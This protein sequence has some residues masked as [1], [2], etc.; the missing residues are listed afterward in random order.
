MFRFFEEFDGL[1]ESINLESHH[2]GY[3]IYSIGR[4]RSWWSL[5]NVVVV[6][7]ALKSFFFFL[8][9][10]FSIKAERGSQA[11]TSGRMLGLLR[12]KRYPKGELLVVSF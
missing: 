1:T 9:I 11:R 5:R 6:K 4:Y 12:W 3:F 10:Y 8:K 2:H 7:V